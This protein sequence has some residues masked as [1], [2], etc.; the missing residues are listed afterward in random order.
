[1]IID[2]LKSHYTL[3]SYILII[4]GNIMNETRLNGLRG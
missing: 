4:N 1:M 2:K 3:K